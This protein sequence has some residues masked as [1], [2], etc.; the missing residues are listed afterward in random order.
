VLQERFASGHDFT[1]CGKTPAWL[2]FV[3]GH[4]FSRAEMGGKQRGALAPEGSRQELVAF[5]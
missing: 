5:L 3:S 2:R 4:D 1:G